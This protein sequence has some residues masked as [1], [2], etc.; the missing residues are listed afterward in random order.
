MMDVKLKTPAEDKRFEMDWS[1]R[2]DAGETVSSS[3]W[4]VSSELTSLGAN[5][6]SPLTS[7]KIGGGVEGS[8]HLVTNQI[9]TSAGN[10]LEETFVVSVEK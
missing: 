9:T 3:S 6:A 7:T 8:R 2:L 5:I 1:G 10:T 4:V